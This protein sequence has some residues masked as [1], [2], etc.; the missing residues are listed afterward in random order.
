M[1][2]LATDHGLRTDNPQSQTVTRSSSGDLFLIRRLGWILLGGQ[3]VGMLVFSTIEYDRYALS[4]GFGT[5]AQA[6]FAIA[7]GHLDP[8]STLIHKPFWRNDAEFI[9][10]PLSLLYYVYPHSIDLLWIQDLAIFVTELTAF[11]WILKYLDKAESDRGQRLAVPFALG[12]LAA[13]LLDPFCYHAMAYDFHSEVLAALFVVLAGRSLWEGRKA[14]L[15]VW[16]ALAF[17]ICG[18]SGLYV[19][20]L[21]IS[22][23]AAHS[24][25]RRKGL[26]LLVAGVFW[27]GFVSLIGGNQFGFNNSLSGWYGYLLGA[28]HGTVHPWD[29]AAGVLLH[30]WSA[31][32][33]LLARWYLIL[34]FL[35]VAG[36]VGLASPWGW[37]MA[38]VVILPSALNSNIAFLNPHASFQTWPCLMFVLVGSIMVLH[39]WSSGANRL[40]R[41]ARVSAATWGAALVVIAVAL[42]PNVS[43]FW[44]SV[45]G[46]SAQELAAVNA[47]IPRGAEVIASWGVV[48]RFA[49]GRDTYAYGPST[50]SFKI[51]RPLVVFVLAPGQ[52]NFEVTSAIAERAVAIVERRFTSHVL[53]N[54]NG[55]YSAEW[56]VPSGVRHATL[57]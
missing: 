33:M 24:R 13:L 45:R 7:H 55:V 23:M 42:V 1:T 43:S 19:I 54:Q 21:G 29:L 14:S 4:V 40:P 27:L 15:I 10:W 52:G 20:G 34:D 37:P 32:H 57:P 22:G 35:L 49:E 5:Y 56:R 11:S 16:T 26:V 41:I 36:L 38:A 44:L 25:T 8:V 30:P 17:L 46:D 3:L 9:L 47:R 31:L 53:A 50:R 2:E 12:T 28:H 6:W 48:G 39:K 18:F 51:D